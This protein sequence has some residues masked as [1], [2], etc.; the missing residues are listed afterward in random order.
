[1]PREHGGLIEGGRQIA[2]TLQCPHCGGHFVSVKGSG[3]RRAFCIRCRAIT[4]GAYACDVCIPIEAKLEHI[5]G[6]KTLYDD[7][8]NE[9]LGHGAVLF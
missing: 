4:C 1:M 2:S 3:K 9:L 5:E 6:S 7:K 8:I